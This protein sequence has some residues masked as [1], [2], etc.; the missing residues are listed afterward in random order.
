[1][2]TVGVFAV[3][4]VTALVGVIAVFPYSMRLARRTPR[5]L[6]RSTLFLSSLAQNAVLFAV[7]IWWGLIAAHMFGRGAPYV[8]ALVHGVPPPSH[9]GLLLGLGIGIACG[10]VLLVADLWFLPYWPQALR[11]LAQAT[12]LPENFLAS[13]YGGINEELLMRLFGL[14]GLV[15]LLSLGW[16]PNMATFWLANVFMAGVFAVGHVPALKTA[17]GNVPPRMLVR[18][19]LLNAPVGLACG[20]LFWTYGIETAIVAHFVADVVYHVYGTVVLRRRMA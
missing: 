19:L 14:S 1:M 5:T 6:P 3:L 18:T 15:W 4:F 12:T 9:A 2:P 13:F 7:T 8:E 16:S 17:I 10:V 20:W 11:E